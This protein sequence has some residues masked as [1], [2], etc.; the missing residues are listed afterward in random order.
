[1]TW[2]R[3]RFLGAS[4]S[5]SVTTHGS[6]GRLAAQESDTRGRFVKASGKNIVGPTG[7]KL[8]LRGINLGNWFEPEGY[9][10]LFDKGPQSPREIEALFN[11]LIGPA[12]AEEFWEEYRR[13]YVTES[14]IQLIR[15][16]GLNSVRIP[17][18]YKF[19]VPGGGGFE[20]LDP[21]L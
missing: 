8:T 7:E 13:R 9:M 6:T 2:S 5:V 17:L 1:M 20:V 11:Q 15:R 19:F 21:A 3:R 14:D 4:L 12:A 10:F 16:S 18:H